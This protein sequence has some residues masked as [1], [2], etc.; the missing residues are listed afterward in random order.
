MKTASSNRFAGF[1]MIELLIAMAV[2]LII[3]GVAVS[4]FRDALQSNAAV[5]QSSDMTDNLRAGLNL[6][7][8]D[9]QQAGEGIPQSGIPIPYTS[10]GSSTAPCGTTAAP[11]RP[12]L[13]GTATFPQCN[14]V[15]PSVEPGQAMGPLITA[16]DAIAGNPSN[17]LSFTDEITVLYADNTAVLDGQ[18]VNKPATTTPVASPACNGTLTVAGNS[19][20]VVFDSSCINLATVG[21]PVL[22]GDLVMFTNTKG[23]A[24]MTV[25]SVAGQALTFASGDAFNLNGRSDLSGTIK[26]L[27]TSSTCGGAPACFPLTT[28]TRI[29]MISYYLDNI[30]SP[31]YIRLIRRVNFNAPTPVGETLENLQFT[32]NFVDGAT[33]PSN[34]SSIP[35]GNSESQIRSVNI[36][37]GARSSYNQ[38]QGARLQYARNNLSTQISLRSMSYVNKYQ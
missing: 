11:N 21:T 25:T 34:L 20:T 13:T 22:A 1:T 5:T 30:T 14:A 12:V 16:P 23:S 15:L 29:M 35:S 7:E 36:F 8:L 38:R 17:P 2:T 10:N 33:N 4:T 19:L 28:A 31:P 9:I 18:P 37:L 24:I 6:M 27:E 26:Q 32:Y 3:L